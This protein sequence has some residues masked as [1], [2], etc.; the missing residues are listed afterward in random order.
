M[1]RKMFL[2]FSHQLTDEQKKD[3]EKEFGVKEFV[4]LPNELKQIWSQ[5]DPDYDICALRE[6]VTVPIFNFIERNAEEEDIVLVQGDVGACYEL[7]RYLEDED[8]DIA[9]VYATTER[10]SKEIAQP[11][12]TVKKVSVFKHVRFRRYF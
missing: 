12:G 6:E 8:L 4:E 11:D 9:V 2:V 1:E 7:V 5:I 3:A 10:D